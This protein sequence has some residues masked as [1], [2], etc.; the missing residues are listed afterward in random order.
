VPPLE[1]DG[2]PIHKP[3]YA[4]LT[5]IDLNRGEHVWQIPFGDMPSLRSHPLLKGVEIPQT[6]EAP[7]QH[8]QSGALVTAGGLLFISSASPYLYAFDKTNGKLLWQTELD[9]GGGFGSPMT[10]RSPSGRQIVVVGTSKSQGEDAKLMAFAL[11]RE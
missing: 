6:G 4:T 5:A 10:Y 1:I 8:G 2:I 3:P 7:P 11:P 9:G